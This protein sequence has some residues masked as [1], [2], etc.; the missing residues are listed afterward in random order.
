MLTRV[1]TSTGVSAA[2]EIL[3]NP[4]SVP[5]CTTQAEAQGTRLWRGLLPT[6]FEFPKTP[7]HLA[8]QAYCVGNTTLNYPPLRSLRRSNLS[9]STMKTRL[10]DFQSCMRL[11]EDAAKTAGKWP[12]NNCSELSDAIAIFNVFGD[13]VYQ[14][15][16]ET[17]KK[18]RA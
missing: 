17:T 14:I 15:P 2:A 12:A 13:N 4:P 1:I 8:W 6:T 3:R 11:L 9:T 10:W 18:T 5:A 16:L 7:V